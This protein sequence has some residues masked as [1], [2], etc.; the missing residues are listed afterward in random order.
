MTEAEF[1]ALMRDRV[2]VRSARNFPLDSVEGA[3]FE[4]AIACWTA[5]NVNAWLM[6]WPGRQSL[7]V[8]RVWCFWDRGRQEGDIDVI[9]GHAGADRQFKVRVTIIGPHTIR[10]R[11]VK[12]LVGPEKEVWNRV[13]QVRLDQND[14]AAYVVTL[15]LPEGSRWR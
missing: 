15:P 13:G 3:T 4:D 6:R 9:V 1:E 14:G 5:M 11:I 2:I 10:L 8:L 12:W 7:M